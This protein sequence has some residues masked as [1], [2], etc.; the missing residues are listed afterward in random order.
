MPISTHSDDIGGYEQIYSP[1][2]V[3]QMDSLSIPGGLPPA[4]L[5]ASGTWVTSLIYAM[6]YKV[7]SVGVTM[8]HAGT[9]KIQRY[10]DRG[11]LVAQGA[12]SS[13]AIVANTPLV[14]NLTDNLPFLTFTIEIDN[15]AGAVGNITNFALLM[16]AN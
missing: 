9:L 13:T 4:Q 7:L 12:V 1:G 15:A 2:P 3:A 14:V 11:G 6:G 10:I 8:D 16:N 5:L